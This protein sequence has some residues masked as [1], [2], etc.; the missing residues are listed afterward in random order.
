[1]PTKI[2]RTTLFFILWRESDIITTLKKERRFIIRR[3]LSVV[4]ILFLFTSP[5][6]TKKEKVEFDAQAAWSYI[7]AMCTDEM[8]GRKSGQPGGIRGEEYIA[9]KFKEWG[10]EPAGDNGTYFQNFTIEHRHIGQ[11]VTF[12]IYTKTGHRDLYYNE[13]WRVGRYSGSG[14][15]VADIVSDTSL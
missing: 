9:S 6:L 8:E 13:D 11:G 1:M 2:W 3:V 4:L 12:E 15:F 5:G 10:L 7:K 14:H